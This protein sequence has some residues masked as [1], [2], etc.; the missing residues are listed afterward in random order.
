MEPAS[1]WALD[2]ATFRHYRASNERR[3][4]TMAVGILGKVSLLKDLEP[5]QL[6]KATEGATSLCD[7]EGMCGCGF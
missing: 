4:K 3:M 7:Q 2:R 6:R 5:E 1:L